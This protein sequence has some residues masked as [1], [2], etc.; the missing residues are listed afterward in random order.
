[1]S[2]V[3]SPSSIWTFSTETEQ[4]AG[5]IEIVEDANMTSREPSA[6]RLARRQTGENLTS[7][8]APLSTAG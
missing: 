6:Q 2:N 5:T 1:M 7:L 8:S 4:E 3:G